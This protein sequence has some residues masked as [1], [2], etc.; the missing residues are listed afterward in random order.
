MLVS[1]Y[2]LIFI[3]L[4][5]G[6]IFIAAFIWAVKSGQFTD[7]EEPKYQMMRDDN[8]YTIDNDNKKKE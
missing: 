6:L 5:F 3:S 8:D 4:L 1:T 7:I 2:L